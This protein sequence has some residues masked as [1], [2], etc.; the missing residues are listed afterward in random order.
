[1]NFRLQHNR[2]FSFV[3]LLITAAVF[4]LFFGGLFFGLQK[5]IEV[6]GQSKAKAG[7]R[8]LA[9]EQLE[10]IR[11]LSYNDVGT[12][13]GVPSG[14]IL[15]NSSTTLNNVHY[16]IRVL[17][18]YVDDDADGL[19]GADS[20]A[21]ITDYKQVKIAVSWDSR[22]VSDSV[23]LVSTVIPIGIETTVGGGTIKV[24][25]FDAAVLP[26][27]AASVRFI[28][29]T[30]TTTIDTT[31]FTD[32]S[33][34]AYLSGAPVAANY[35]IEVTKVGYT[36][37]GTYTA[38]TS[39]PNPTTP[40]IAVVESAIST[41]NFQIDQTSDLLLHT[42]S[43]AATAEFSDSFTDD[44]LLSTTSSTTVTGGSL[45][46]TDTLGVYAT[47]GSAVSASSSPVSIDSWYVTRFSATTTASTSVSVSM[48]YDTGSGFALV[49]NVD[50]PGNSAGF[51]GNPMKLQS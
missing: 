22:G 51:H 12:V 16:S 4:T 25:V 5:S 26:V 1:M 45:V 31:R 34:V 39:N 35:E 38:S 8:A 30:T 15:Q 46:L 9:S 21:I 17:V 13:S 2:G 28:N 36:F 23:V 19:L 14:S 6:I 48:Y 49:P 44:S 47:S 50:L 27:D 42:K 10:F 33:G 40:P 32:S 29:D 20:N 41:M 7:A 24:N 18:E 3:E 37:D 43:V 11:S